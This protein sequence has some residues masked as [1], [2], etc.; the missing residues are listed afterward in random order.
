MKS[1]NSLLI[2]YF[3]QRVWRIGHLFII[4]IVL[5]RLLALPRVNG[6][7][8]NILK[9]SKSIF[10]STMWEVSALACSLDSQQTYQQI[11]IMWIYWRLEQTII[12]FSSL[13]KILS[14]WK[15]SCQRK[16]KVEHGMQ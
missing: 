14:I 6:V 8:V 15:R 13:K 16:Y 9:Q 7:Q 12:H 5:H 2:E 3:Q 1:K 10:L 11:M 4:I